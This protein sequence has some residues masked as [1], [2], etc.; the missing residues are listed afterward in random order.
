[1]KYKV[2]LDASVVFELLS[3]FMVYVTRKWTDNLDIG[4]HFITD[5]D[6]RLPQTVRT[7]LGK[8]WDWPFLD[9]DVLYALAIL[10]EKDTEAMS[11]VDWVSNCAPDSLHAKLLAYMPSLPLEHLIRI[12]TDYPP[13][14][15]L[16]YEH[17][18]SKIEPEI[19][20]LIHEDAREKSVLLLKMEPEGLIEYATGGVVLDDIPV[21]SILLF[22]GVHFRP[23]NTYCFY[24]NVLLIQYPVDIP[25][26]NEDDPPIVLL[27][28]T[29]ALADPERLKLLRYLATEPKTVNDMAASLRQPYDKLMHHLIILRAAG[30]L[31]SHVNAGDHMERF[32]LRPDGASEL[33]MFFESYLGLS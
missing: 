18:F 4:S 24:D 28:M 25:E 17:Y 22:P 11:F 6:T 14:L 12:Q 30:L 15:R 31:R 19:K 16:W 32:S 26:E 1:M 29:E 27:R 13:L 2:S 20:P 33:Q 21:D 7:E 10:R 23:I 3:S 9:Y 5:M 8:A